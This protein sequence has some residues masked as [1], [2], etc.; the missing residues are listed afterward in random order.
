MS[1][2]IRCDRCQRRYRGH[3]DW[4]AT[5]QSG[6]ITGYLCPDCQTADENAEATSTSPR[7]TT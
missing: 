3:D 7:S 2:T 6:V 4:N 1:K 5:V